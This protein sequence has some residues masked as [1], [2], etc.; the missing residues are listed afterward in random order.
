MIF[1]GFNFINKIFPKIDIINW[2][3]S[4]LHICWFHPAVKLKL[5]NHLIGPE[6][7]NQQ[8][9]EIYLIVTLM[10]NLNLIYINARYNDRYNSHMAVN[11]RIQISK[12]WVKLSKLTRIPEILQAVVGGGWWYEER[13]MLNSVWMLLV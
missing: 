7:S 10:F 4:A 9:D 11:L 1:S 13:Q 5:G 2:L 3:C 12:I 6:D 8:S